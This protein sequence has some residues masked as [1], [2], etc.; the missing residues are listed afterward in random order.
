MERCHLSF[1]EV[2]FH[3]RPAGRE[4]LL[5][6]FAADLNVSF[7]ERHLADS[8]GQLHLQDA[9]RIRQHDEPAF[10]ACGIDGRIHHE[11]QH[12]FEDVAGTHVAQRFQ[13][14]RDT[15]QIAS[16]GSRHVIV[17]RRH[18][19]PEEQEHRPVA[20]EYDLITGHQRL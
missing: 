13:Q 17:G 4:H 6:D 11:R 7:R 14:H 16:C 8:P 5:R 19:R 12:L 15:A 2:C 20:A 1:Q 18:F 10:G 9:R 3:G